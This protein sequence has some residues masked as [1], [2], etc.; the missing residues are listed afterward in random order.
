MKTI[1]AIILVIPCIV[2]FTALCCVGALLSWMAD[3]CFEAGDWIVQ[4]I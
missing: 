1:L 3:V 4:K 2:A